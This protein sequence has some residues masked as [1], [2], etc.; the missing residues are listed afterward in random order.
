MVIN[1]PNFDKTTTKAGC[2]FSGDFRFQN[3][4]GHKRLDFFE[5]NIVNRGRRL[6]IERIFLF[7]K[8]FDTHVK[9]KSLFVFNPTF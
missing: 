9:V 7:K 6:K 2:N 5:S 3:P 8:M 1:V 4:P